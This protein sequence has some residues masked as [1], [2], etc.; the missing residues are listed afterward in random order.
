MPHYPGPSNDH[1]GAQDSMRAGRRDSPDRFAVYANRLS[2]SSPRIS[3][4]SDTLPGRAQTPRSSKNVHDAHV[5]SSTY[6]RSPPE[7]NDNT[8]IT[9]VLRERDLGSGDR[10]TGNSISNNNGPSHLFTA[11]S[12]ETPSSDEYQNRRPTYSHG[13][14]RRVENIPVIVEVEPSS[15]RGFPQKQRTPME[16]EAG[17]SRTTHKVHPTY[18]SVSPSS[19]YPRSA[20][21]MTKYS[22]PK[23]QHMEFHKE[24]SDITDSRRTNTPEPV[25]VTVAP[26]FAQRFNQIRKRSST[27]PAA[28]SKYRE[29]P[30]HG[31]TG[32]EEKSEESESETKEEKLFE[33]PD[34]GSTYDSVDRNVVDQPYRPSEEQRKMEIPYVGLYNHGNTCYMSVIFQCLRFTPALFNVCTSEC[35]YGRLWSSVGTLFRNMA[36]GADHQT[37]DDDIESVRADLGQTDYKG[38]EQQ[39]A[40]EFLLSLLDALH[41]EIKKPLNIQ[42]PDPLNKKSELFSGARSSA[43]NSDVSRPYMDYGRDSTG[44]TNPSPASLKHIFNPFRKK[45]IKKKGT[46]GRVKD[47]K[48]VVEEHK[49]MHPAIRAW[50]I[51]NGRE[52]STIK[53]TFMSQL[54]MYMQC[55]KCGA[56]KLSF[57]VLWNISVPIPDTT[58]GSEVSSSS[59]QSAHEERLVGGSFPRSS[60]KQRIPHPG[61]KTNNVVDG[62]LTHRTVSTP[63][64]LSPI[65]QSLPNDSPFHEY[66]SR[67]GSMYGRNTCTTPKTNSVYDW[68]APPA[69]TGSPPPL[70]LFDQSN[71]P[72]NFHSYSNAATDGPTYLPPLPPVTEKPRRVLLSECLQAS[73]DPELLDGEDKPYCGT[74]GEKTAFC[75]QQTISRLPDILVIQILRFHSRPLRQKNTTF[76]EFDIKLNIREYTKSEYDRK[77]L[78]SSSPLPS[79][80]SDYVYWLYAVVYHDG[81]MSFGHYTN[82]CRVIDES[83]ESSWYLFDDDHVR[84]IKPDEVNCASAYLLFYESDRIYQ[85]R[86]AK[87]MSSRPSDPRLALQQH[88][89]DIRTPL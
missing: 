2:P 7:F 34:Y 11:K 56:E 61:S 69:A 18:N 81:A 77:H 1:Y 71:A 80:E 46:N 10:G 72:P 74:C 14:S 47:G 68:P 16:D 76:V 87:L 39:D 27:V 83:G 35:R 26:G 66:F 84:K 79:S 52:S 21:P 15:D 12:R 58:A 86:K 59:I 3:L 43:T 57:G 73:V 89:Q 32:L 25:M 23:T 70:T 49:G 63:E 4:E 40:L 54:Q 17:R 8:T 37:L 78:F 36:N 45:R 41:S 65:S 55:Q 44:M 28:L 48:R 19:P 75:V 62:L 42:T 88:Q 67:S 9:S 64:S 50:N 24:T 38:S 13:Y 6:T 51:E 5:K 30:V 31:T 33:S 22:S 29:D 20:E 82:A 53:D 85:Q 60:S